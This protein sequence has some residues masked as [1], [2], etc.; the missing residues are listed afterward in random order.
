MQTITLASQAICSLRDPAR[1][2]SFGRRLG[3][4][5]IAVLGVSLSCESTAQTQPPGA[6]QLLQQLTLP[7][8][9]PP[10]D[11][12]TLSIEKPDAARANSNVSIAIEQIR[13]T[14]NDSLPTPQLHALVAS[15]EGTTQTLGDLQGLADRITQYYR[16]HGYPLARAY[17]PAQTIEAGEVT[18]AVLEAKYGQVA[19]NNASTTSD[20]PL[21]GTLAPLGS[22]KLVTQ[23]TLDRTLLLLSD[24][25]GVIVN[26]TNVQARRPVRR[27]CRSMLLRPPATAD[28]RPSTTLATGTPAAPVAARSSMS[29]VCCTRATNSTWTC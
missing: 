7:P 24:I 8:P 15:A 4:L 22:G 21:A 28:W 19:L 9:P 6:G 25:P 17:V 12:P 1:V 2:V 10:A 20:R 29:T 5:L 23:D 16:L 26:S 14:G 13:I 11:N 3:P 18:L 27:I